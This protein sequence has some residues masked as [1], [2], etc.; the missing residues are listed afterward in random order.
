M[1]LIPTVEQQQIIDFAKTGVNIS[2]NAFAGCAKSSTIKMVIEDTITPTLYVMFNKSNVEDFKKHNI[3]HCT[4]STWHSLAYKSIVGSPKSK[5]GKKLAT[6]FNIDDIDNMSSNDEINMLLKMKIIQIIESFCQSSDADFTDVSYTVDDV[7]YNLSEDIYRYWDKLTNENNSVAITH[8]VY[9]KLFQLKNPVL[10]YK[11]ICLDEGQD[12]S[13]CCLDIFLKQKHA[14]LIIVGDQYQSIYE[15]RG[16]VNAMNMLDD[17]FI[18]LYLNESF[19]FTQDIA[20]MAT[21]LT[22]IIGNDKKIIGRNN[23]IAQT[24]TKA[25]LV[26]KN[27]TLFSELINAYNEG[28]KVN[29]IGSLKEVWSALFHIESLSKGMPVKYPNPEIAKFKSFNEFLKIATGSD[30]VP[31]DVNLNKLLTIFYLL[32]NTFGGIYKAKTNLES[33]VVKSDE[34]ITLCTAH[35]SKGLEWDE[36]SL[37]PDIVNI[38]DSCDE[39]ILQGLTTNQSLE[40]LY[41]AM[42]RG[43]YKVNIPDTLKTIIDNSDTL[44][45]TY[46]LGDRN[47]VI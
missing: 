7:E 11:R 47:Y 8:D 22:N 26:R 20:D 46:L 33:I 24:K 9:L 30:Q 36:V 21:K 37:H 17:S 19:R 6:C 28:L 39:S 12:T 3:E 27:T 25:I 42:T 35:K 5:F 45:I 43:K 23:N 41:V 31:P 40:L 2:I 1:K 29:L 44:A 32:R 10:P 18:K 14:Q 13:P 34:D 4:P 38:D 16:A 15:W